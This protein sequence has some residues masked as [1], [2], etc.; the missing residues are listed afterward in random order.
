MCTEAASGS[1]RPK[2]FLNVIISSASFPLRSSFPGGIVVVIKLV[3]KRIS[4]VRQDEKH[5]HNKHCHVNSRAIHT[6]LI[7]FAATSSNVAT[8][9]QIFI[10]GEQK[11]KTGNL[12]LEKGKKGF[13]IYRS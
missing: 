5:I 9:A 6:G 3:N 2:A 7:Q 4:S 1:S 11:L 10:P 8:Q 12:K 13:S